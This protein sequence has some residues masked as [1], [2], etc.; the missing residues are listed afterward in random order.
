MKM[1]PCCPRC[2]HPT[3]DQKIEV[4]NLPRVSELSELQKPVASPKAA[5]ARLRMCQRGVKGR[6]GAWRQWFNPSHLRYNFR[7]APAPAKA[8]AQKP[9]LWRNPANRP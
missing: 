3:R 5:P 9:L 2:F 6:E 8:A 1:T 4:W 7:Y